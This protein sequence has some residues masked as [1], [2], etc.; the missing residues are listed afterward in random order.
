MNITTKNP[1]QILEF[2][3][4]KRHFL[5]LLAVIIC[6]DPWFETEENMSSNDFITVSEEEGDEPIELPTEE[7]D[8]TLL[9]TTL[10]AQYPGA[11]GLKYRNPESRAWRGVRLSDGRLFPPSDTGWG[12]HV[13]VS[14][15]PKGIIKRAQQQT[16]Y[17]KRARNS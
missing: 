8:Y 15:L 7:G 6:F 3:F 10:A 1:V 17:A 5:T 11:C 9:L 12:P 2:S 16:M 4:F 13:Y 14:V